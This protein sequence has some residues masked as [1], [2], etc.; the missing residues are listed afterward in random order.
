MNVT[1]QSNNLKKAAVI[2]AHPDDEIIWCGGTI[3]MN[4]DWQWTVLVL[5]RGNDADRAPKFYQVVKKIGAK[6]RIGDLDDGPEQFPLQSDEVQETILSLLMNEDFDL[7][8]T[9]NPYGEYT[10]HL[11]HEETG[12]AVFSLWKQGIISAREIWMFAY[13]DGDK[14]HLPQPIKIAPRVTKLPEEI[15]QSKYHIITELYGFGPGSFEAKTTPKEEA[16]WCFRSIDEC[17]RW[18]NKREKKHENSSPL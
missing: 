9:H 16:F 12:S 4:P 17:Q 13:D 3:L 1:D 8:L 15:W 5:C 18:L 14:Q 6:G 2:V 7:I 11:R 10:R